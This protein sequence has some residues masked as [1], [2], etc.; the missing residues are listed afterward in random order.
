MT[1]VWTRWEGQV[2]NGAY[3]LRRFLN[4]SSHSAVFLTES[5]TEG[6]LN[7]AI[8]IIPTDTSSNEVQLW[9][10]KTA[11]TFHHPHL[12]GLLDSGAFEV[13]GRQFL[14]VVMEYAEENLAQ[15]LPYRALSPEEV[16]EL[17]VPALAR[18]GSR[19]S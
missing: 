3:P 6:F 17:L 12:M 10:W 8:K 7:A 18:T 16:R 2:I 11:I 9:H 15:I 4:A 13:Q 19:D 14:F 1:E 5:A